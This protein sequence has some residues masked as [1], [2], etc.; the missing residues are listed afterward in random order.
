MDVDTV[1]ISLVVYP[2]AFK[3]IAIYMPEFSSATSF[4][5]LPIALILGSIFPLLASVAMLHVT[6]PLSYVSSS[7]FKLYF[8]S[9]LQ[10]RF[11]NG[12]K[13]HSIY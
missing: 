9:L 12:F 11:I 2:F 4:I 13:V 8:I 1:S 3:D 5:E 6:K 10:L 7:I